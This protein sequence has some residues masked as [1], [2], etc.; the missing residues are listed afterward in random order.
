MS[1]I[2][3]EERDKVENELNQQEGGAGS[4]RGPKNSL[5]LPSSKQK[6]VGLPLNSESPFTFKNVF[7]RKD[8]KRIMMHGGPF[9]LSKSPV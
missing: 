5:A 3:D 9:L 4:H 1:E 6:I 2:Y 7:D 8:D